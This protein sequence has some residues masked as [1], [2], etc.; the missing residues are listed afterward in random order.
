MLL[1]NTLWVPVPLPTYFKIKIFVLRKSKFDCR[2]CTHIS[3]PIFLIFDINQQWKYVEPIIN[4][5]SSIR[6][7]KIPVLSIRDDY[8]QFDLNY[9]CL[10]NENLIYHLAEKDILP[11]M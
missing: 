3:Q 1:Y 6:E 8:A 9:L 7:N 5:K 2:K 10:M 11:V 4:P